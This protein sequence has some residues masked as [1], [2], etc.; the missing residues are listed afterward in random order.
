VTSRSDSAGAGIIPQ[1]YCCHI[2]KFLALTG[3]VLLS[4][5][6]AGSSVPSDKDIRTNV[7]QGC[8]WISNSKPVNK[9]A[10]SMGTRA[11]EVAYEADCI[12]AGGTLSRRI[13]GTLHFAEYKDWFSKRWMFESR[14]LRSDPIAAKALAPVARLQYSDGPECNAL[15]SRVVSRV[16]PCLKTDTAPSAQQAMQ[17]A[18]VF[19]ELADGASRINGNTNNRNDTVNVIE[20]DCLAKWQKI[21]QYWV[22]TASVKA[23]MAAQ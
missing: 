3:L 9:P 21:Q 11:V 6:S 13:A 14:S 20:T 19:V 22:G 23:C 12:P 1:M 10:D 7:G 16:L 4:A 17:M 2:L 5:C 18:E 8:T 15:V